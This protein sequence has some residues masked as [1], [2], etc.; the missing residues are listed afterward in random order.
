M[1]KFIDSDKGKKRTVLSLETVCQLN[2]NLIYFSEC[3]PIEGISSSVYFATYEKIPVAIKW[4]KKGTNLENIKKELDA[5]LVLGPHECL[6]VLLGICVENEPYCIVYKLYGRCRLHVQWSL[7]TALSM[8]TPLPTSLW[9]P[10]IIKLAESVDHLHKK[11][12][13]HG[14]L[15][16]D[17]ILV[18]KDENYNF[19]QKFV[20]QGNL[21]RIEDVEPDEHVQDN[22]M[23]A[24]GEVLAKIINKFEKRK[25]P[26]ASQFVKLISDPISIARPSAADIA[27]KFKNL[28][29]TGYFD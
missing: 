17:H 11:G 18:Y 7:T 23:I 24:L 25:Y 29:D 4:F 20:G 27:E 3:K 16:E 12:H 21:L 15:N 14:D 5:L 19:Y 6:P 1:C 28:L 10:F 26:S 22:E 2:K 8:P 13:V 9:V